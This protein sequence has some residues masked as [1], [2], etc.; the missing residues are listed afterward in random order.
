VKVLIV[1]DDVHVR[2]A[3]RLLLEQEAGVSSVRECATLDGLIDQ[4]AGFQPDVVLIDWELPGLQPAPD[5]LARLHAGAPGAA[6][7]AL[8]CSPELRPEALRAGAANFV[9]KS[10]A[11]DR[12]V[13]ILRNLDGGA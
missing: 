10:D 13:A 12:L 9:C 7:V 2:A 4:A 3:L 5:H 11:P 8:S 6:V 1:D